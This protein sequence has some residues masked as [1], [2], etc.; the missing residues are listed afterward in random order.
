MLRGLKLLSKGVNLFGFKC[1]EILSDYNCYL[2]Q[3]NLFD[4]VAHY[5]DG[6]DL[7]LTNNNSCCECSEKFLLISAKQKCDGCIDCLNASDERSCGYISNSACNVFRF[8]SSELLSR[9]A[10]WI[11]GCIV[12][13]GNSVVIVTI[14]RLLWTTRTTDSLKLQHFIILN[15][16]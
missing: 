14:L 8:Q 3:T 9:Y 10:F 2:P 12:L 16:A 13:A 7:C 6:S 1:E 11:I 4:K 15:V 5:N